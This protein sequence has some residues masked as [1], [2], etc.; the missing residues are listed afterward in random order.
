MT[1][2]VQDLVRIGGWTITEEAGF[3]RGPEFAPMPFFCVVGPRV[4]TETR[5]DRAGLANL[6]PES[7]YRQFMNANN[8]LTVSPDAKREANTGGGI[9]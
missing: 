5:V 4:R 8:S 9:G 2:T 1:S 6:L 3:G 7:V